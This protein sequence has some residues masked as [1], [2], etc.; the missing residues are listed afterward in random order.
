MP[1]FPLQIQYNKVA[2][3]QD[4]NK[5]L[6]RLEDGFYMIRITKGTKRSLQQNAYYHGVVC[7]M[8]RHGLVDIGYREIK[9]NDQVHDMLKAMFLKKKMVSELSGDEIEIHGSTAR[10]T[11]LEFMN[12]IDE[13]VQWAGEYLSISI[14]E[15]NA[16]HSF[17]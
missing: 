8:V 12:Y 11:K 6:K 7:E 9:N 5:H 13:I 15:P 16:S 14:P 10:L 4:V 17:Y 3:A 2:N 1:E